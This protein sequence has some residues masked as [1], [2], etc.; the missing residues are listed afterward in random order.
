M[1]SKGAYLTAGDLWFCLILDD[2][3]RTEALPEYTH[4]A[5]SVSNP[6][7]HTIREKIMAADVTKWQDNSSE[8]ESL[9]ILDPDGHKLELHVG[10]LDS[11]IASM[12]AEPFDGMKLFS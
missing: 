12:K 1:W 11:R 7:F 10:D 3:T 4:L 2:K 8:G 5:F 9:Y 6:D